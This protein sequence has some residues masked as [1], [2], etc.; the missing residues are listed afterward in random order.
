MKQIYIISLSYDFRSNLTLLKKI[1][2]IH[3]LWIVFMEFD[4]ETL[5]YMYEEA[6]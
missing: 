3:N 5:S 1:D 6:L 4:L 2:N